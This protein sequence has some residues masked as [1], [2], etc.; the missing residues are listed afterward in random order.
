MD[1][2]T[3]SKGRIGY[4]EWLR[5]I[6]MVFVILFHIK[7]AANVK[8]YDSL[9]GSP[10]GFFYQF[11]NYIA[12]FAVPVFFMISGTLLLDPCR[13][14]P[15]KKLLKHYI[16]RYCLVILSF[17]YAYALIQEIIT[18]RSFRFGLILQAMINT[19][20]GKTW[21]HMWYV[22]TY[23]GILCMLPLMRSAVKAMD[24][25]E[26]IFTLITLFA[27][28]SVFT[29]IRSVTGFVLGISF[30]ITGYA[31]A[32]VLY[33]FLGYYIY[34]KIMDP[35][36]RLCVVVFA[37]G[38]LLLGIA[39]YMKTYKGIDTNLETY[40]SPLMV[41]FSASI[42]SIMEKM[43]DHLPCNAVILFFSEMSFGVYLVHLFFIHIAYKGLSI[44]PVEPTVFTGLILA[45]AVLGMSTGTTVLLKKIP[46][47]KNII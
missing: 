29:Y 33:F 21:T 43:K 24:H 37:V 13:N 7:T 4:I 32:G 6:S 41:A 34:N 40:Y 38:V 46:G 20:Q 8:F 44:N 15:V 28:V 9:S 23:L 3:A 35:D 30:P 5:V 39:A 31:G 27:F 11:M 17:G 45:A 1:G 10:G 14:M 47:I 19:L 25:A 18:L 12:H 2:K 26:I 16:L 42:Y 22:Y 36:A